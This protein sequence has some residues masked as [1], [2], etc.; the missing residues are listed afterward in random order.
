MSKKT[1]ILTISFMFIISSIIAAKDISLPYD[2]SAVPSS[3]NQSPIL[4][5]Q[6]EEGDLPP[7]EERVPEDP[8]V[9]EPRESIGEYGGTV[10]S[11]TLS[12]NSFGEDLM[13][14]DFYNSF[15]QPNADASEL[16]LNFAKDI[17]ISED[18]KTYT[19]HLREGVKWSD[20]EPFTTEDIEFWY[21]DLLLNEEYT[22][23]IGENYKDTDGEVMDLTIEDDY[24]FTVEFGSPKPYFLEF[25][26]HETGWNWLKAKHYLKEYHPDYVSEDELEKKLEESDYDTWYELLGHMDDSEGQ[27]NFTVGAPTLG[28]YK[29]VS[30]SSDRR[31]WE[32]NPYYWK[33]DSEG[34]QLPYIDKIDTGLVSDREVLNGEI[35]SGEIDFAA[36]NTDIRNYP[37]FRNY[38]EEGNYSTHRWT[39]GFASDVIYMFNLT[40]E[41]EEL[42]EV[43]Q[44]KKFRQAMSLGIDRSEINE[45][46][47]F[48]KAQESQYTVLESSKH[49]KQEFKDS[50]AEYDPDRANELLD[51]V[52]LEDQ[53]DDGWRELPNGDEFTFT[54]E[55]V[56]QETP[57]TPN[58]ELATEHWRDLG[59]NVDSKE[60]SGE[61]AGQRAPAN[62]MDGN[63][64]HG[65]KATDILFPRQAM[66]FVPQAPGWE[67]TIWPKWGQWLN[68]EGEEGEEPPEEIKELYGWWNEMMNEPDEER[69]MELGE[70]ILETQAENLWTIGTVGESPW[71]ATVNNNLRNIPEDVLW[72]WDTLW[73]TTRDP[74]QFYF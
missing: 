31:V 57:K 17:E 30:M 66:F 43:F 27:A 34:N 70:K 15:V 36:Y 47:Y 68:T 40:H 71:V 53:D 24:T 19:F 7:V 14:M 56:A 44:N 73:T 59:L 21:E 49:F 39:S 45:S 29:L 32:R 22:P 16:E 64:W 8:Y 48:G 20:G 65:D 9:V 13:M 51:E 74:E 1:L 42:R 2:E 72:V 26:V 23:V 63:L 60:I 58:V 61:L 4:D 38:E 62:L 46:I 25:M 52:G 3:F 54:L 67:R 41:E 33:V 69:R 12:I 11:A 5:E 18:M 50:Y 55:F 35:M 6:V 10:N 37:M 28:P